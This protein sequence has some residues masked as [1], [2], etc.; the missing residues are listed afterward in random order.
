VSSLATSL[1]CLSH[2]CNPDITTVWQAKLGAML[3]SFTQTWKPMVLMRAMGVASSYQYDKKRR[4]RDAERIVGKKYGKGNAKTLLDGSLQLRV[5]EGESP[6]AKEKLIGAK[7]VELATQIPA[8]QKEGDRNKTTL[9][10]A[11]NIQDHHHGTSRQGHVNQ[12][13]ESKFGCDVSCLRTKITLPPVAFEGRNMQTTDIA[14]RTNRAYAAF[15]EPVLTA[16]EA[17]I[18]DHEMREDQTTRR[19]ASWLM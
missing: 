18:C 13:K 8:A 12:E 1:G 14:T 11:D 6:A 9:C 2:A 3:R 7:L 15:V 16:G 5:R 19:M 17:N 4:K 10:S